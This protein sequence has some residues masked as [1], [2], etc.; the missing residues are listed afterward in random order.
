MAQ[1]SH[2]IAR[3]SV[4]AATV[5]LALPAAAQT[6][7]QILQPA[8]SPSLPPSSC[9]ALAQ[10]ADV[11]AIGCRLTLTREATER[12]L[13]VRIVLAPPGRPCAAAKVIEFGSVRPASLP[14]VEEGA[15]KSPRTCQP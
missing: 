1:S 7:P 3:L 12:A 9:E 11:T 6:P 5:A 2:L 13:V 8:P 15:A 14:E 4:L 10:D